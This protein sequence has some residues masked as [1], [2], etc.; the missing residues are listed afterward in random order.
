MENG[1]AYESDGYVVFDWSN[2]VDKS[3]SIY[4]SP[5][6]VQYFILSR[7]MK[8]SLDFPLWAPCVDGKSSP[9][10]SGYLTA[11]VGYIK[12]LMK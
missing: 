10:G 5:S 8:S 1:F 6:P 2:Y 12:S 4:P 11:N 3:K 7:R 9:W